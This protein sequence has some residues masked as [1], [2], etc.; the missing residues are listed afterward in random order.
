ML[1]IRMHDY[2]D[3]I[4]WLLGINTCHDAPDGLGCSSV[5]TNLS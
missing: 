2:I 3:E 1:V 5:L 4:G